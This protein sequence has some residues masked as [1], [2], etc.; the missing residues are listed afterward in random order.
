MKYEMHGKRK[1]KLYGVWI[2]MKIRCNN[3]LNG[4]GITLPKFPSIDVKKK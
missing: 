3:T 1:I 4:R 2:N